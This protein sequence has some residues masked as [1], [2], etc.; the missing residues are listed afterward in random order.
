MGT[1][2]IR[3]R[4]DA[5]I[6]DKL[7][8][9]RSE[10][11]DTA[12]IGEDLGADSLDKV[13]LTMAFEEEFEIEISDAEAEMV[14][15]VGDVLALLKRLVPATPER[16]PVAPFEPAAAKPNDAPVPMIL[17]PAAAAELFERHQRFLDSLAAEIATTFGL[18]GLMKFHSCGVIPSNR[19]DIAPTANKDDHIRN[20]PEEGSDG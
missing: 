18:P 7:G 4:M 8:V 20:P 9:D 6:V 10:L 5:V 19:E 16:A 2:A 14:V 1:T 15:T 12:S 13:E 11:T 3:D 17:P